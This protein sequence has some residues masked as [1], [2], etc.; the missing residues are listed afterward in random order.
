MYAVFNKIRSSLI[1]FY[2]FSDTQLQSL[3]D[4]LE[5]NS[6]NRKSVFS[7]KGTVC[8]KLAF[9]NSGSFRLHANGAHG[10]STLDFFTEGC[11]MADFESLFSGSPSKYEI[12]AIEESEVLL[13]S[14]KDF[15]QLIKEDISYLQLN[16]IVAGSATHQSHYMKLST[17]TP[18]ERFRQFMTERSEWLIRFPQRHIASYLGM[19]GSTF[20]RVKKKSM[21]SQ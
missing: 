21:K 5:V 8:K 1:K 13:L 15:H 2:S 12:V 7:Q 4:R 11:W 9:V 20:S 10:D 14:L 6:V 17:Q 3:F 19:T 16:R 18:E